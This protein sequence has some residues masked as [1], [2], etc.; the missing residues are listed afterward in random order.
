MLVSPFVPS[1]ILG[2]CPVAPGGPPPSVGGFLLVGFLPRSSLGYLPSVEGVLLGGHPPRFALVAP[3]L[4]EGL[5]FAGVPPPIFPLGF[6][7]QAFN[8]CRRFFT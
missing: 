2:Q 8:M 5:L 7:Y 6:V 4:V 3:L 1:R